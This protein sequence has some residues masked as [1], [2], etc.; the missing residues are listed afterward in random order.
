MKVDAVQELLRVV[1]EAA[2]IDAQALARC[3]QA[4]RREFGGATLRIQPRAPITIADI[5][6]MLRQRRPVSA[7]AP[8][9]GISRATVYR[10]IERSRKKSQKV[11]A[12]QRANGDNRP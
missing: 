12:V 7:I 10:I 9:L 4:V 6:G 3:E 2:Q 5:D 8:Q 11:G 1:G